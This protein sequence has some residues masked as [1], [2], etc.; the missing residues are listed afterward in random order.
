MLRVADCIADASASVGTPAVPPPSSP[1]TPYNSPQQSCKAVRQRT[2]PGAAGQP[3]TSFVLH[4]EEAVLTASAA[5]HPFK[6][7]GQMFFWAFGQSKFFSGALGGSRFRP[8]IFFGSFSAS[9]N[10]APPEGGGEGEGGLKGALVGGEATGGQLQSVLMQ[11]P[12]PAICQNLRGAVRRS[13]SA[14]HMHVL[15]CIRSNVRQFFHHWPEPHLC[16]VT[17]TFR[18]QKH[19]YVTF[20]AR[21]LSS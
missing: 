16:Y 2:S 10:S 1:H 3:W 11:H 13:Q 12:P 4:D 17:S 21:C 8:K 7:L 15:V 14:P 5:L 20:F 9:K 6:R 19:C 18:V